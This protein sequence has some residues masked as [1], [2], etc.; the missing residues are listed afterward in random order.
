MTSLASVLVLVLLSLFML[1]KHAEAQVDCSSIIVKLMSCEAFLFK[2]SNVPG[3]QCCASVQDLA[4]AAKASKDVLRGTCRCLKS[5]VQIVP[6]DLTNAAKL[7]PLCHLDLNVPI[8][9]SVDCDS[10]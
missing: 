10:L 8:S 5:A 1:S 3:P 2:Y 7:T 4:R 9:P 6:V